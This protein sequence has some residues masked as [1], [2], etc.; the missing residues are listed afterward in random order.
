M[1]NFIFN[2]LMLFNVDWA[3]RYRV[4]KEAERIRKEKYERIKFKEETL[5]KAQIALEDAKKNK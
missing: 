2:I 1:T 4:K 5:T 3:I